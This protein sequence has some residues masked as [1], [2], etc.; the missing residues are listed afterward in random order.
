[1]KRIWI[2][3]S[4]LSLL[5][6]TLWLLLSC[7]KETDSQAEGEGN[8]FISRMKNEAY[9]GEAKST[10]YVG[11]TDALPS[12]SGTSSLSVDKILGDSV[13]VALVVNL[14]DGDGFSLGIPGKQLRKSWSANLEGGSFSIKENGSMVGKVSA[15]DKEFTWDGYLSE[16]SA[17]LTVR[18]KYLTAD[19]SIP[20]ASILTTKM[21]LKRSQSGNP[22]N[23]GGCTNVVWETRSVFNLYSGGVDLIRIPVCHP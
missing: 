3:V 20:A 6:L 15:T 7:G 23:A 19:G 21:T 11:G 2:H 4:T 17:M 14:P 12:L 13:T 5:L 9:L 18:I 8:D 22:G 10:L 1:M 16:D